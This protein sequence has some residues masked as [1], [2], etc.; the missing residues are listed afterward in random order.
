MI[1]AMLTEMDM[2]KDF[3]TPTTEIQTI[4]FGG[5]TPSI[6]N[7]E[8]LSLLLKKIRS[9]FNISQD[10]E[11]TLEINPEDVNETSLENWKSLGLNR[12]SI[13][14]QTFDNKLLSYLNRSHD[15]HTTH[16]SL[17]LLSQFGFSNFS[18]DLIYG[19]PN[20]TTQSLRKDLDYILHLNTP[21]VSAYALTIE[22]KTYFGHLQKKKKLTV[23]PDEIVAEHFEIISETL[24]KNGFEQY[25]ISN[26]AKIGKRSRHNSSYW[27]DIPYLGIGPGAHSYNGRDR[28]YN[29]ESNPIYIR[30]LLS[31]QLPITI[32][33]YNSIDR[34]NEKLLTSI[35]TI[36]GVNSTFLFSMPRDNMDELKQTIDEFVHNNWLIQKNDSY[37]LSSKGKLL[38][39]EITLK[40]IL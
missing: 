4:Y 36:E 30:S 32:E 39:D 2:R 25:E 33:P 40:L 7:F 11:I 26:Y 35:R 10:A 9:S 16:Q 13:G 34:Y 37:V 14:I 38:A 28:L 27:K 29:I 3:F 17:Q 1:Q 8:E 5:G 18:V 23:L 24:T 19:I 21:H 20:Q 6:L 15:Q 22:E 31:R 12:F